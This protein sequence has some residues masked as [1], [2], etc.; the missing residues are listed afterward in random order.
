MGKEISKGLALVN[1][2]NRKMEVVDIERNTNCQSCGDLASAVVGSVSD[3]I[4][5]T[6]NAPLDHGGE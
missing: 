2:W 1:I 5:G 6:S 4:S 3:R